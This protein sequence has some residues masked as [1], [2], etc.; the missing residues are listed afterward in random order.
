MEQSRTFRFRQVHVH[1]HHARRVQHEAAVGI[2][3][4]DG[5]GFAGAVLDFPQHR[6]A[7]RAVGIITAMMRRNVAV[8]ETVG[9]LLRGLRGERLRLGE[10]LIRPAPAEKIPAGALGPKR[11]KIHGAKLKQT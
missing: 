6:L 8:L 7:E 9:E 5:G 11:R 10:A 4:D 1:E 2:A 3:R